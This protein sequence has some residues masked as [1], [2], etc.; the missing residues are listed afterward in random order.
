MPTIE[1]TTLCRICEAQCGLRVSV[2][3]D[4]NEIKAIS[5]DEDHV[6]SKGYS[7]IKGL[8]FE[9]FRRSPDRLHQPLKR[10]SAKNQPPEFEAISWQQAI[11]E[12]GEKVRKLRKAHGDECSGL[13]FGNPIAFSLLYPI[14][15]NGFAR[16]L[17]TSKFFNTGTLDCNNKFYVSEKMYGSGFSLTFPDVERNQFLMIIGGNPAISKMS[18]I[19]LPHPLKKL[20]AIIE[21]G[22]RVIHINP[23]KTETAQKNGEHYFIRPD[24]DVFFLLSFL[25]EILL[26]HQQ[27]KI[28]LTEA[29]IQQYMSGF[30]SLWQVAEPWPAEKTAPVTGINPEALRELV[31]AYLAADGAALYLSTGV[32]QGSNGT[33]AFWVMEVINAISGNL[34]KLGGV[35]MGEGIFDYPKALASNAPET[36]YSRIGNTPTF[37]DALPCGILSDEILTPGE[38]QMKALFVVSGNPLLSSSNSQRF[39]QALEQLELLVS[40]EI[41]QNET[42]DFADYIL[43]G[44][45]F[46]ERPDIPFLFN[47]LCGTCSTPWFQYVDALVKPPGDARD[48]IWILHQ[49]AKACDAPLFGSRVF[50]TLLNTGSILKR[51]PLLGSLLP[52]VKSLLL[53]LLSRIGKQGS[54]KS[55]RNH[56]HGKLREPLKAQNYLGKRVITEDR[57]VHLAP[58]ELLM[59]A[60]ERLPSSFE[61]LEQTANSLKL[62]TKRER[63]SHNTWTHNHPKYISKDRQSNYLYMHPQDAEARNITN[64]DSVVVKSRAGQV[65]IR[66]KLDDKLMRGTVALPHGWGHAQSA[67]QQVASTTDG[68]NANILASDGVAAIEPLSGMTQFNGIEVEVA[69]A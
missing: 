14:F 44:T 49:L 30:D 56:P 29:R 13:Y 24:T 25:R 35:Q 48:E 21:R 60:K 63:F 45:H 67:G 50:Q 12:I 64:L 38:G 40:I 28:T 15:I 31:T 6:M 3:T 1:T 11:S 22:G 2:D 65:S 20:N 23:R 19:N 27:K 55:L 9:D 51:T 46:A 43:P 41:F 18:F 47:S 16:G 61:Q 69:L 37:M 8:T 57:K 33:L 34:D 53:G 39:Q 10:V 36:R 54:L 4:S 52:D 62:I 42:A 32:N 5:P 17:N 7:C 68:V 66:A 26:R 58:D 59:L